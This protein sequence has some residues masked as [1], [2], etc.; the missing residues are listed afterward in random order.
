L[1][2]ALGEAI[3]VSSGFLAGVLPARIAARLHPLQALRTE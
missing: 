1:H 3:A 2:V